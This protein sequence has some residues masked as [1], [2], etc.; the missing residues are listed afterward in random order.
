MLVANDGSLAGLWFDLHSEVQRSLADECGMTR[1]QF[2]RWA[3]KWH[4]LLGVSIDGRVQG[5]IALGVD[6]L[7]VAVAK[8]IKGRW[9]RDLA[10]VL[11]LVLAR[12][13]IVVKT[14]AKDEAACAFIE[15]AGGVLIEEVGRV[16]QYRIELHSMW[17][18]R[19]R[20]ERNR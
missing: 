12:G 14:D 11:R 19:K 13:P 17:F 7:H 15:R 20:H 6:T 8:E 5:V 1:E 2:I 4:R 16:K 9:L 10:R 18:E 3:N